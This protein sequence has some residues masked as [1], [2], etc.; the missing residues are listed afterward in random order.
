MNKKNEKIIKF[1]ARSIGSARRTIT[2][3]YFHDVARDK[4]LIIESDITGRSYEFKILRENLE[5]HLGEKYKNGK[6]I[7]KKIS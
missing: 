4:H 6:E 5:V 7:W 1:R 3:N 2:G